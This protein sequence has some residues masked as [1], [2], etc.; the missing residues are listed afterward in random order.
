MAGSAKTGHKVGKAAYREA[1]PALRAALLGAQV[2]LHNH[3][4]S[5]VVVL[6]SGQD[7][8]G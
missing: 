7:G 3:K 2:D 6:I 5:P 1:V 4:K 8:S